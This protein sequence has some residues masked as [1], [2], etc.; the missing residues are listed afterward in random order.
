M[1]ELTLKQRMLALDDA[2]A[3]HADPSRP[4]PVCPAC[5]VRLQVV[6]IKTMSVWVAC[7][8]GHITSHIKLAR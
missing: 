7:P 6:E 1:A 5:G 8:E 2:L 4:A 3:H